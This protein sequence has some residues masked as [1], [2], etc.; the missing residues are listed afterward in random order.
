ME[1]LLRLQNC[2]LYC[3]CPLL[4]GLLSGAP[5][6]IQYMMS[7]VPDGFFL[8]IPTGQIEQ[9]Y[10]GIK[11]KAS[12]HFDNSHSYS[13]QL[14]GCTHLAFSNCTISLSCFMVL[15]STITSSRP[16][17]GTTRR[18]KSCRQVLRMYISVSQFLIFHS[19]LT[20]SALTPS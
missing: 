2:P 15:S 18:S 19:S 7:H 9:T 20:L 1:G 6:Y 12:V 13:L 17:S 4:R 14:S 5:L 8:Q 3:G 16:A 10:W 11:Y